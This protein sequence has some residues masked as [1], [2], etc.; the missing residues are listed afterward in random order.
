MTKE[1]AQKLFETS[2]EYVHGPVDET[3]C[4]DGWFTKE[5]L[6][7]VLT[8]WD[9]WAVEYNNKNNNDKVST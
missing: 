2:D 9:D 6:V 7:A 8:L 5:K 1:E 4:L 3:I